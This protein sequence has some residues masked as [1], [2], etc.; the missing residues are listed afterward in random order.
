MRYG[1]QCEEKMLT[2]RVED[3]E[4]MKLIEDATDELEKINEP[5]IQLQ[6]YLQSQLEKSSTYDM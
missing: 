6:N 4:I 2:S 3:E 5:K 1:Q